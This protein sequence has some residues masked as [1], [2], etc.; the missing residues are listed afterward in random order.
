MKTAILL[1]DTNISDLSYSVISEANRQVGTNNDVFL[2]VNNIS[3]RVI[4]ADC[5]I[6]NSSKL[7][8]V[9][10]GLVIAT[11]VSTANMLAKAAINATK[12]F[13][14]FDLEWL[15]SSFNF[16]EYYDIINDKRLLLVCRSQFHSDIIERTFNRSPDLILEFNLDELWNSL[17]NIKNES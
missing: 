5:A 15:Y 1:D 7:S 8:N 11:N 17:D 6:I 2:L 4:K 14:V 16:D 13:F 3:S 10:D 9:Y 12:I